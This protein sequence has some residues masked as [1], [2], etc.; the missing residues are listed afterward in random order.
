MKEVVKRG[1][2]ATDRDEDSVTV[3]SAEERIDT[4][5]SNS[6]SMEDG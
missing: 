4:G 1:H 6:F 5:G 2:G 3:F